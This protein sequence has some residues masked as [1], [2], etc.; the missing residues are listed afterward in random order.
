MN[1]LLQDYFQRFVITFS[2]NFSL[3]IQKNHET[4]HIQRQWLAFPFLS[5]HIF[6]GLE[7]VLWM[8][9]RLG[10]HSAE[11]LHEHL[12]NLHQQRRSLILSGQKT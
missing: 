9:K 1:G 8:R 3:P 6:L 5:V 11:E 7:S 12:L 4:T 10:G 2:C